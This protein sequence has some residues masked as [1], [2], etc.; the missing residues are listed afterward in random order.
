MPCI[1]LPN[2]YLTY[3]TACIVTFPWI[4]KWNGK[5]K[6]YLTATNKTETETKTRLSNYSIETSH[7]HNRDQRPSRPRP[8]LWASRQRPRPR[9]SRPSRPRF[10]ASRQRPRPKTCKFQYRDISQ[11]QPWPKTFK[12]KTKIMGLKTKTKTKTFKKFQYPDVLRPS[13][14]SREHQAWKKYFLK[15]L[16]KDMHSHECLLVIIIS[17]PWQSK[18][19]YTNFLLSSRFSLTSKSTSLWRIL[20]LRD[21]SSLLT[22][23]QSRQNRLRGTVTRSRLSSAVSSSYDVTLCH[24]PSTHACK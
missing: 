23:W 19:Y 13:L 15:S 9:P 4:Q 3:H 22:S 18:D 8:R 10:W 20:R 7:K 6:V 1:S 16:G 24:T 17:Y 14:K 11:A 12:T 5:L 2:T 21:T